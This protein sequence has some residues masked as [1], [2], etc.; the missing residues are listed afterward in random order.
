MKG[1]RLFYSI[2]V[3][4]FSFS[5]NLNLARR[6]ISLQFVLERHLHYDNYLPKYLT[7]ERSSTEA[8]AF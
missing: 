3:K 5:E 7:Y 4:I 8:V 2:T 6:F 1:S